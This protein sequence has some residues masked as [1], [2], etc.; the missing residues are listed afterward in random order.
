MSPAPTARTVWRATTPGSASGRRSAARS[1]GTPI[2]MNT[3]AASQYRRI[4]RMPASPP[5]ISP[6]TS[7]RM[8]R[9]SLSL[10]PNSDTTTSFAPGG[11]RSIAR[12]PSAMTSDGP[13]SQPGED[14]GH[15]DAHGAGGHARERRGP[16]RR[17]TGGATVRHGRQGIAAM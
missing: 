8:L 9:A 5:S 6:R 17:T 15:R 10:V 16:Y 7:T 12:A 14:L 11:C 1:P 3:V 4:A 2:A 13:P